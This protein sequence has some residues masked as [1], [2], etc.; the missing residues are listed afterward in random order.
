M[1]KLTSLFF[2]MVFTVLVVGNAQGQMFLKNKNPDVVINLI[3]SGLHKSS[4]NS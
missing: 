3:S 1:S 4:E 2:T